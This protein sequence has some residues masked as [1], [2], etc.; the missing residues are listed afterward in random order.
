MTVYIGNVML[1]GRHGRG[2]EAA[3]AA[4]AAAVAVA[5]EEEKRGNGRGMGRGRVLHG[6]R[7]QDHHH[8]STRR[9]ERGKIV[10]QNYS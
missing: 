1:V 2:G 8:E 7:Y 9:R 3:T 10:R 4:A 6:Q 5:V